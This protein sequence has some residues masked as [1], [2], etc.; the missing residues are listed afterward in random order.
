MLVVTRIAIMLPTNDTTGIC[1]KSS[2][3]YVVNPSTPGI[4][5]LADQVDWPEAINERTHFGHSPD[6]ETA[7]PGFLIFEEERASERGS[8]FVESTLVYHKSVID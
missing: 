3:R 8:G 1:L 4:D 6:Q 5:V 2:T 7:K